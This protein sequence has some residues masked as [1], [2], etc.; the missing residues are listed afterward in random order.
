MKKFILILLLLSSCAARKVDVNKTDVVAKVDSTA[1]VKQDVVTT[2]DNHVSVSTNTDELEICPLIDT[3]PMVVNGVTYKNAKLSY[4]KTKKVLVDTTK[5][6][7]AEK[8]S[9]KVS[10]KKD[11]KL[12]AVEKKIDK[13]PSYI[14]Y[15]WWLLIILLI[16][17]GYYTYK[18]INRT[19][20]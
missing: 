15:L 19:L 3:I 7:V 9:I 1:V 17:A 11:T 10:V 18:K 13:K 4:R 14:N 2:Q 16:S 12:K 6:K 8:S 5:I 20:F